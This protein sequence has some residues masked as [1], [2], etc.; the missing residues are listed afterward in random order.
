MANSFLWHD[1]ETWGADPRKDRPAQ[2]AA[3]R[4]DEEFN[5]IGKPLMFYAKPADDFLPQ[6][7]ACLITGITP[8]RAETEGMPEADFFREIQHEMSVPGTCVLGYNSIRFDDEFTRFGL[9]RNFFDP[10]AREW[11]NG[12]S[13][14]D[15]IDLVRLTRA[16]RPQGIQW[17]TREDGA[18]SFRLE[19]LTRANSIEHQG[20]HDALVDVRAT[21]AVAQL[22]RSAQPK[23]FDY[24][25]RNRDKRKL[26]EQL[27]PTSLTPMLHVSARY[28]ANKGCIASVLP[29]AR[30]P[31][32][33]NSVI[34]IDLRAD[35]TQLLD[36]S[37]EEIRQRLYT[38]SADLPDGVE[39]IPLKEIKTNHVPVVVPLSTI[40]AQA[41][42]EWQMDEAAERRHLQL[43][44]NAKGLAEKLAEV[45]GSREFAPSSDPD[46]A[47][48]DGF[49][50][51]ADRKQCNL[52]QASQ[53]E[54]LAG[55]HP[56]F[57]DA[58]LTELFFRYRARNWPESLTLAERQRWDAW[59]M[60]R[61]TEPE[62]GASIC[63]KEYGK[64]LSRLAI[65]P[66]L[67]PSQR[68]LVSDLLDWPQR[69][70]L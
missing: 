44:R 24:V 46:Q 8:Q 54:Q 48:Y 41:R 67:N 35:P 40:T 12:N 28:P 9:Y 29:L 52:I 45:F 43:L 60:R 62:A 61:L 11:Q 68:Q 42:E 15:I 70:G 47:L 27:E 51:P 50:S 58:K 66:K 2:F 1:Y 20:A 23:L 30:H 10:Y 33:Q 64:Q 14:W 31:T 6:P 34:V 63:F 49:V 26:M 39:R 21:I 65:D 5:V 53:P 22:V 55:L 13:R 56:R 59:R 25:Y 36:L 57:Q 18:P 32:N 17:P 19:D 7:E 4:T 69:I 16:L 3:I 38:A 37:V